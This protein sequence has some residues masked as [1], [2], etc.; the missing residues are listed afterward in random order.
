MTPEC[1]DNCCPDSSPKHSKSWPRRQRPQRQPLPQPLDFVDNHLVVLHRVR[2]DR[3]Q[4]CL[5][6]HRER[7]S[8]NQ[9]PE[10]FSCHSQRIENSV[11]AVVVDW[12][13]QHRSP[14]TGLAGRPNA[15]D[16]LDDNL[17]KQKDS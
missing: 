5:V 7:R 8:G 13:H 9:Q 1:Y 15:A 2:E 6:G 16:S 12:H 4:R 3:P 10:A 17:D 14:A 11:V